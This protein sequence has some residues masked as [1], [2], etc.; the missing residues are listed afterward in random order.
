MSLCV[1][2]SRRDALARLRAAAD[3]KDDEIDRFIVLLHSF[4]T[5]WG[6]LFD[7]VEDVSVSFQ[8][9]MSRKTSLAGQKVRGQL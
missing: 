2:I 3:G 8:M 4:V 1:Q 6:Q 9:F 5:G 7:G